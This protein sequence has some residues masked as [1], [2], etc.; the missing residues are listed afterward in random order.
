MCDFLLVI[1]SNLYAYLASFSHNTSA[2]VGVFTRWSKRQANM[3]QMR[4]IYTCTTYACFVFA[5]SCKHPITSESKQVSTAAA[6]RQMRCCRQN[7]SIGGAWSDLQEIENGGRRAWSGL[8][9]RGR[10]NSL[11]AGTDRLT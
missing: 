2:T 5:L 10:C 1:N 8:E 4:W 6:D 3:K 9:G 11:S 7:Q